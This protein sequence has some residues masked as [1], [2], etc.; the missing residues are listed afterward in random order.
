MTPDRRPSPPRW[1]AALLLAQ[2]LLGLTYSVLN[3]L[4]EA[5]DEADHYAYIVYIGREGRLPEGPT[6]TQSKHPPLYHLVAAWATRW[7]GLDF[8]FLRSNPDVGVTSEAQ[9]PNFFVHTRLEDW[10]WRGG[11]LAM[12]LA[13]LLSLLAGLLLTAATYGLGRAV[14]PAWPGRA[15]AAAA[16]VA[17]LPE[18]LF[19]GGAVNNDIPAAALAT[20]ALWAT[21]RGCRFRDAALAGLFMGLGLLTKVST[22]ALW[23]AIALAMLAQERREPRRGLGRATLAIGLAL[24][25]ATPWLWRNWR[26]YGDPLGTPLVLAT[27]DRRPAPLGWSDLLWLL[28]GWFFSFWGKFGGAGHLALPA[29]LYALWAGLIGLAGVGWVLGECR[30]QVAGR[31]PQEAGGKRRAAMRIVHPVPCILLGS[32]L[33]VALAVISYSRMALGTDQ[34]RLLFPALAPIALLLVGGLAGLAGGRDG[35]LWKGLAGLMALTAV[36]A[37]VA[38]IVVPFAPPTPPDGEELAQAQPV[39]QLFGEGLELAAMRWTEGASGRPAAELTLYWRAW[40]P[41]AADLRSALRVVDNSGN[42]IWEWKR[43]PGAGRL[44]TDRWPP[45]RV[46]ADVYRIPRAALGERAHVEVGVYEFPDGPW[47]PLAGQPEAEPFLLL[48]PAAEP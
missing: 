12:H 42:L 20:L 41:I 22:G 5:P 16:F 14:W 36:V 46:V 45:G 17:F 3:P 10:P 27:V 21:L 18:A 35:L 9:A 44:S 13:R 29:P 39:G 15:L 26:L 30:S 6:V 28:R 43:S 1:L 11:A 7:T 4:G 33:L 48:G 38:G 23:P 8:G 19:I 25:I 37:L 47:L 34:G 40:Q 24:L 2:L 31:R 32:P